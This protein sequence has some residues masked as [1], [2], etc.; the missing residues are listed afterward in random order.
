MRLVP[1]VRDPHLLAF[2]QQL[3]VDWPAASP[4]ASPEALRS[5]A[6]AQL[7]RAPNAEVLPP[8]VLGRLCLKELL[9]ERGRAAGYDP[10]L[11]SCLGRTCDRSGRGGAHG[12]RRRVRR[13]PTAAGR[14]FQ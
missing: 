8:G 3:H 14:V 11:D 13:P 5:R 4:R 6:L 2:L 9:D 7:P 10:S 1:A 12:V